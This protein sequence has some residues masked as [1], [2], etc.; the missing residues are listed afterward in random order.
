MQH[1]S[2]ETPWT[3][4]ELKTLSGAIQSVLDSLASM[5]INWQGTPL[6][7]FRF[8]R[9]GPGSGFTFGRSISLSTV[10]E[11]TIWHEMGH[12]IDAGFGRDL[13][14]I[15]DVASGNCNDGFFCN[16]TAAEGYYYRR[17]GYD[18]I[19]PDFGSSVLGQNLGVMY[20]ALARQGETWSDAFAAWVYKN[21]T[22]DAPTAWQTTTNHVEWV[23]MFKAV[24]VAL[25]GKFLK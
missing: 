21:S 4:D 5:G 12:A 13:H 20:G 6:D 2:F 7:G 1:I 9:N 18:A 3:E 8:S 24:E 23:N 16:S 19:N 25:D 14:D 15:F 17:Y 22:G 10:D 11:K